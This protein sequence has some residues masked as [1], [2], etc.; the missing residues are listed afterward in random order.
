MSKSEGLKF[1]LADGMDAFFSPFSFF[2][3]DLKTI[4]VSINYRIRIL[5]D[6]I[7]TGFFCPVFAHAVKTM[8][9]GEEAILT[10]K[11]KCKLRISKLLSQFAVLTYLKLDNCP[12]PI[13]LSRRV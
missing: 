9:E 7:N 6:L 4:Y 13:Y 2:H 5:I 1:R 10:V 11:P 8:K 3:S 12:K